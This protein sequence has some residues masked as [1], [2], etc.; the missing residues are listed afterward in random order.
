MIRR[1]SQQRLFSSVAEQLQT[2]LFEL[3]R[4]HEQ[5]TT[6]KVVRKISDQPDKIGQILTYQNKTD[7]LKTYRE[8][9]TVALSRWEAT[10]GALSHLG[11]LLSQIK[12]LAI[13]GAND[14]IGEMGRKALA[15]EVNS[16]LEEVFNSL[17]QNWG[18]ERLFIAPNTPSPW[19]VVRSDEGSIETL[20]LN[21]TNNRARFIALEGGEFFTVGLSL[22]EVALTPNEDLWIESLIQLKEGLEANEGEGIRRSL[23]GIERALDHISFLQS[24]TGA[25][26][27]R[28]RLIHER[29]EESLTSSQH[30]LSQLTDG[31]ILELITRFQQEQI[32]YQSALAVSAK[33]LS[34]NLLD[35]RR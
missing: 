5:V 9:L 27:A 32:A 34:L 19:E 17:N 31:D 18:N 25:T 28:A 33:L 30:Q 16:L 1:I 20:H 15:A 23:E 10:S 21:R 24:L 14:T 22:E 11:D 12:T 35:M 4:A 26:L 8:N 7:R 29:I 13:R 2:R 6:G 3:T